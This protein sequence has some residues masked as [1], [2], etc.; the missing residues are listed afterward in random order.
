VALV[1]WLRPALFAAALAQIVRAGLLQ[2]VAARGLAA[3]S[4]VF[5]Q[6]VLK[7]FNPCLEGEDEGSQLPHQGPYG[8]FAP[9]VGSMDIFWGRHASWCHAVY[10]ARFLSVLHQRMVDFLVCLSSNPIDWMWMMTAQERKDFRRVQ[11]SRDIWKKRAVRRGEDRR[12]IRQ[13]HQEVDRSRTGWRERALE[14]ENRTRQL[15]IEHHQLK[16]ALTRAPELPTINNT[17]FF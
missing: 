4:A 17:H 10:C 11:K 7:G 15:E 12:R 8:F 2:S 6:V 5:P 1:A 13:R 14:A 3:V 9:Q 16:S